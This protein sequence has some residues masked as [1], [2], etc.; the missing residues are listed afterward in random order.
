MGRSMNLKHRIPLVVLSTFVMIAA[1]LF[2]AGRI[3]AAGNSESTEQFAT[4][5][6][7]VLTGTTCGTDAEK[8]FPEANIKYFNT[9]ADLLEVLRSGKVDAMIMDQGTTRYLQIENDDLKMVGDVLSAIDMAPA[10]PK[11]EKGRELCEKYSEFTRKICEDGTLE[12]IDGIWFGR[13]ESLRTVLDYEN[14]PDTNGTLTIAVDASLPPFAY[15]KDRNVVGY[16]VDI[17]A[18]FCEEY[19]Y[20]LK[21]S[22]MSFDSIL[23]A[24]ETAKCDLASCGIT[25]TEER[26]ESMLFGEP[27]FKSGNIVVVSDGESA[28]SSGGGNDNE[29]NLS[30]AES[31]KQ[32][33]EKTFIREDRWLLFVKGIVNTLIITLLSILLGTA[34][35]FGVFMACRNGNPVANGI[36][37]VSMWLVQGMPMVV[38]LMV[39]YYIVFSKVDIAGIFVAVAGFTLTFGATVFGLLK[40]GVGAVDKGQYEASCALGFSDRDTFFQIILPQALPHITTAYRGE[41]ISLIKAT[42]VVGYIA[43]QDLTKMG[44]IVRSRTYEA[45]FP[46]IAVTVIYFVL[47]ELL[48]RMAGR[49]EVGFNPKRRTR[50]EILKGVNTHDKN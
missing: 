23:A 44:D 38:L 30:F 13:D 47:E 39:L 10:F 36:T 46:L 8:S 35:G 5:T 31:I 25:V 43:V 1:I 48:A 26:A 2:F 40:M 16:D 4:A 45:F 3:Y 17:A 7:G 27:V 49:I 32:S 50:E 20:R 22:N 21:V 11:T 28:A 6:L 24:V 33:F 14:L 37:R 15:M 42:S 19:G 41:I 12:E 18:R 29:E 34:L 9:L